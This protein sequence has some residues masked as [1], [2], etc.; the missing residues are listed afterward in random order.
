MARKPEAIKTEDVYTYV[1]LYPGARLERLNAAMRAF[2]DRYFTGEIDGTPV[3]RF[4]AFSL[5]PIS[6][7]H[8]QPPSAAEMKPTG[9]PQTLHAMIG[10]ALLI[11]IVAASNFASMM[12]ARAARRAV[13]VAVRKAVGATRSQLVVQFLGECLFYAVLALALA[14]I[15][16][17]LMLPAFNAFLQRDIAFD[18]VR[19]STL[20]AALVTTAVMTGL[21]AGAYPALVLSMFRPSTVLKGVVLLPGG[22]SARLLRYKPIVRKPICQPRGRPE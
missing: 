9:D 14:S 7:I 1:K 10:I 13:E 5:I 22:G 6:D 21:A 17:E 2:A 4:C 11:V 16:V 12:T 8:L 20:G 15:A 3:S 18:Y 19:D